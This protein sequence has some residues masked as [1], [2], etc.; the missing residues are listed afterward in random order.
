VVPGLPATGA[1][2]DALVDRFRVILMVGVGLYVLA[3][4][5]TGLAL[6]PRR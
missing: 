2:P 4:A 3:A 5:G 6:A 1:G